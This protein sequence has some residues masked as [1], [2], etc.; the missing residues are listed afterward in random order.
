MKRQSIGILLLAVILQCHRPADPQGLYKGSRLYQFATELSKKLPALDPEKNSILAQCRYFSVPLD[1]FLLEMVKESGENVYDWAALDS[2]QIKSTVRAHLKRLIERRLLLITAQ[3]AG[4]CATPA[5]RDTAVQR[6]YRQNGGE[7]LYRKRLQTDGLTHEQVE[8]RLIEELTLR[9]FLGAITDQPVQVSEAELR[10]LYDRDL[11][12]DFRHILIHRRTADSLQ[13]RKL[14]ELNT[15]IKE[16]KD[17]A[18]LA[19]QYSDDPHTS[20]GGGLYE[21]VTPDRLPAVLA[22]SVFSATIGQ[23]CHLSTNQADHY[24]LVLLRYKERRSFASVRAELYEKCVRE[25]KQQRID[26]LK[27]SLWRQALITMML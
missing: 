3:S 23:V 24:I 10:E 7:Q 2:M 15:R 8:R 20:A 18:E 5:E 21:N 14:D 1:S 13:A 22:E 26:L 11:S 27:D 19:K 4:V 17:F 16:G 25:K 9:R 6:L 12:A